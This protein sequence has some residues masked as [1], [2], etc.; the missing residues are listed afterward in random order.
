MAD[1]HI[2]WDKS[3]NF[4]AVP[5][6]HRDLLLCRYQ[7]VPHVHIHVVPKTSETD[8]LVLDPKVNWPV[9]K[10]VDPKKLK[11]YAETLEARIKSAMWD[12]RGIF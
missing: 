7:T 5:R 8:G 6:A 4:F 10:D 3:E 1:F 2:R 11:E 9:K 12:G